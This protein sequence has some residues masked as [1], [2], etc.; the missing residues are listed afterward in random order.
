M[1]CEL[2]KHVSMALSSGKDSVVPRSIASR[3]KS[4]F[5]FFF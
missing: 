3:I 4:M 2:E 1:M 5:F